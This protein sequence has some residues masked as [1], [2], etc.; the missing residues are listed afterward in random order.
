M[1]VKTHSIWINDRLKKIITYTSSKKCH[2]IFYLK[3][4]NNRFLRHGKYK[5]YFTDGKTIQ[6]QCRYVRGKK[7]G[8]VRTFYWNQRLQSVSN[9]QHD[10]KHGKTIRFFK[11]GEIQTI[12]YYQHGKHN[13]LYLEFFPSGEIYKKARM[14]SG[15]PFGNFYVYYPNKAMYEIAYFSD[16]QLEK[17][18]QCSINGELKKFFY[19]FTK[20]GFSYIELD[21]NNTITEKGHMRL[22]KQKH[23]LIYRQEKSFFYQRGKCLLQK[24]TMTNE[25][26]VCSVCFEDTDFQTNCFHPLCS[27]CCQK[28][29]DQ[30]QFKFSCPI[31]RSE[32]SSEKSNTVCT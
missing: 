7:E 11:H 23:G 29:Y 2:E 12:E 21:S 16:K 5:K 30:N 28:W 15:K 13:G 17:V 8:S 20:E 31:C 22:G 27:D 18:H 3:M 1:M 6:K 24:V 19:D 26:K 14:A 32:P 25:K 10:K 9:F 4:Y